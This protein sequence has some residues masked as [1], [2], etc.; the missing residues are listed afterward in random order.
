M[1]HTGPENGVQ[2]EPLAQ[3]LHDAVSVMLFFGVQYY[4]EIVF[5]EGYERPWPY[6]VGVEARRRHPMPVAT[7][8][9]VHGGQDRH[10]TRGDRP[11]VRPDD[12]HAAGNRIC[13]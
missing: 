3:Q 8:L 10:D 5:V 4:C 7:Q 2:L 6:L 13:Q 11:V 12:A 1:V 9:P